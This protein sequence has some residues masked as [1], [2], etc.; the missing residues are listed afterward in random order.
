MKMVD[1]CSHLS[2][3]HH[4][5][6]VVDVVLEMARSQGLLNPGVMGE[7]HIPDSPETLRRWRIKL[8]MLCMLY[9]R[10]RL[11]Q[12]NRV[13]RFL[14]WDSSPQGTYNYQAIVEE[15]VSRPSSMKIDKNNPLG[16][17]TWERRSK[18]LSVLGLG[19][20]LANMRAG[21]FYVGGHCVCVILRGAWHV[22]GEGW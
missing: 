6:R 22:C 1:L 3:S 7:L 8:D 11:Q 15:I 9:E 4:A 21:C 13:V 5:R 16:G 19:M 2:A 18:P 17:F 10:R 12:N 20:G 14:N